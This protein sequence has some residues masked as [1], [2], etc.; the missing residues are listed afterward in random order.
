MNKTLKEIL[1]LSTEELEPEPGFPHCLTDLINTF[2]W[3]IIL[4]VDVIGIGFICYWI[5]L[6]FKYHSAYWRS[7]WV[8]Q[9]SDEPYVLHHSILRRIKEDPVWKRVIPQVKIYCDSY[10]PG[11]PLL[12]NYAIQR[13]NSI[14]KK[15]FD[16]KI[17]DTDSHSTK[18]DWGVN[19][20]LKFVQ[21]CMNSTK[22]PARSQRKIEGFHT[23]EL[24]VEYCRVARRNMLTA[25]KP[26]G[27][28]HQE[29][30]HN[31]DVM[32]VEKCHRCTNRANR[33]RPPTY[34][35]VVVGDE[36][37]QPMLSRSL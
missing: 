30:N 37:G 20:R 32:T 10:K 14:M 17:L 18:L 11:N 4:V 6:L 21:D 27:A 24:T 9:I 25:F 31:Q 3:S 15:I 29:W 1:Q 23:R 2:W 33:D 16:L 26:D 28:Y 12:P 22:Y 34:F 19:Y 13:M 7:K 5:S 36:T 35:S 8:H